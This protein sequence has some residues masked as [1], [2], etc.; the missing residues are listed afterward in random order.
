MQINSF[1]I[2]FV[3]LVFIF[4]I[5]KIFILPLKFILKMLINSILGVI[6]LFL[7]NTIGTYIGFH[8]GINIVTILIVAFLGIPGI[9]LLLLIGL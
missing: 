8:I 1:L 5:C 7:I 2:Y 4:I 6:L 9:I 3:Y